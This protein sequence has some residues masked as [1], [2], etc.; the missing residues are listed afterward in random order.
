MKNWNLY[1]YFRLAILS[2]LLI[3][4]AMGQT[5][6][7]MPLQSSNQLL[8]L[9]FPPTGKNRGTPQR[10]A[11][12][13]TRSDSVSCL[14]EEEQDLPLVALMPDREN[15]SKTS[16][17]TPSLYWYVP[18]TTASKGEFVLVDENNQEAYYATFDLPKQTGIIKLRIPE[19]ASLEPGKIYSWSMMVIC[20]SRNRN[21]DQYIQGKIE[22]VAPGDA[23]DSQLSTLPALE[24]A[25]IYANANL[26]LETLDTMAKIRPENPSAWQEF[27]QS[28]GLEVLSDKN[29]VDCCVAAD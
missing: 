11:G 13:G 29:F 21:R 18:Q 1:I 16:I 14:V 9:Q 7:A 19:T 6:W 2:I 28:V 25:R 3:P 26:W 17:A 27:L 15:E 8:T 10:T 22:Y 20:D 24:Q 12:G 23:V 4:W 5:S